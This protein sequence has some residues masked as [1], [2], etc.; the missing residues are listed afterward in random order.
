[1]FFYRLQKLSLQERVIK[2]YKYHLKALSVQG[3]KMKTGETPL[4]YAK[5]IDEILEFKTVNFETITDIFNKACYSNIPI[6]KAIW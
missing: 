4:K 3:L 6:D 5:R 2:M 1:M